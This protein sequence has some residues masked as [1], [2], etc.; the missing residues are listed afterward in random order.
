MI[1]TATEAEE[2]G[3]FKETALTEEDLGPEEDPDVEFCMTGV[4]KAP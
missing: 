2:L 3:A 1:F 4:L